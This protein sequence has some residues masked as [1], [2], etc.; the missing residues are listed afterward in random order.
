MHSEKERLERE[1]A[2]T[3]AEAQ[4]R[5]QALDETQM[6][7]QTAERELADLSAEQARR[8]DERRKVTS[9][10]IALSHTSLCLVSETFCRRL[11]GTK[12]RE[13]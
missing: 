13:L 12:E 4:A 5:S 2:L 8:E 10:A 1:A 11:L 3:D 7:A 9:V 6:R